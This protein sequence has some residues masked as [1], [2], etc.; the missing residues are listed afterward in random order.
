MVFGSS[1]FI[2]RLKVGHANFLAPFSDLMWSFFN[3]L[4]AKKPILGLFL[5]D[6]EELCLTDLTGY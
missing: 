6:V 5:K 1:H 3:V 2:T 4:I